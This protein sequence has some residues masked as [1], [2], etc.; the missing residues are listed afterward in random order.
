MEYP[1]IYRLVKLWEIVNADPDCRACQEELRAAKKRL[2]E[3]TD[4]MSKE[5]SKIYWELPTC[6][7]TFLSRVLET[8]TEEMRFPEE[9]GE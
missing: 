8:A 7:H 1:P 4:G 6:I 9:I 3:H 2:E 5:E